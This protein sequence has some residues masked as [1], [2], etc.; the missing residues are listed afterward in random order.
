MFTKFIYTRY[1]Y[2][3]PLLVPDALP[4]ELGTRKVSLSHITKTLALELFSTV[5]TAGVQAQF[6]GVLCGF[7]RTRQDIKPARVGQGAGW[8]NTQGTQYARVRE[9]IN[10]IQ[11]AMGQLGQHSL[12]LLKQTS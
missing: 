1:I 11:I 10:Q 2:N 12:T 5:H 7:L 8:R 9:N 6:L 4:P 3:Q